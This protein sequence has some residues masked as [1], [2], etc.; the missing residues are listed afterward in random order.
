MDAS[1][2]PDGQTV[3]VSNSFGAPVVWHPETHTKDQLIYPDGTGF[4]FAPSAQFSPDG[5]F[6]ATGGRD[7]IVRVFDAATHDQVQSFTGHQG[8]V[9]G[10]AW[11][12]LRQVVSYGF[13][14][15]ARIWDRPTGR[16]VAVLRGH[17]AWVSGADFS[18]DGSG[19]ATASAD[20][21][22]RI[23]DA[24]SGALL[25]VERPHADSINSVEFSPDG[26]KILSASDDN[27]AK[28]T[29]CQTCGSIDDLLLLAKERTPHRD[30]SD[31]ERS[32]FLGEQCS[33]GAGVERPGS[34]GG[35]RR[36]LRSS[37]VGVGLLQLERVTRVFGI[38][39]VHQLQQQVLESC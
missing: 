29:T 39:P 18:P 14:R 16:E 28:V 20:K 11:G 15:T 1:F 27:T 32:E 4:V 7:G 23:W 25:A 17:T 10:A 13:D 24:D 3:V 26:A 30:L 37:A 2:S 36:L 19:V 35:G 21:A 34:G 12:D 22:I 9:A 6:I 33:L 5:R 8:I 38:E 31:A